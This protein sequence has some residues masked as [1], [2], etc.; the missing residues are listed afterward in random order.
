MARRMSPAAISAANSQFRLRKPVMAQTIRSWREAGAAGLARVSG[1]LPTAALAASWRVVGN[2]VSLLSITQIL[3]VSHIR[4][5]EMPRQFPVGFL[6]ANIVPHDKIT[7]PG[8]AEDLPHGVTECRAKMLVT[9]RV[10]CIT[11]L[12]RNTAL[13]IY[14]FCQYRC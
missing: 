7:Q 8:S 10:K 9:T 4:Q 3:G 13:L 5:R 11:R 2:I 6:A 12:N 1:A 14:A